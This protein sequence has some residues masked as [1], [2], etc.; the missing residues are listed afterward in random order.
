MPSRFN[1]MTLASVPVPPGFTLILIGNSF[2]ARR[3]CDQLKGDV[4]GVRPAR[5]SWAFADL[6]PPVSSVAQAR[7]VGCIVDID[8]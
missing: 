1:C 4:V 3:R 6:D 7:R 5:R 8:C 2:L